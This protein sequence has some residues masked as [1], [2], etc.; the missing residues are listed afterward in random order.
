MTSPTLHGRLAD[1]VAD[2]FD[3]GLYLANEEEQRDREQLI[4][5]LTRAVSAQ[6]VKG[7]DAMVA[8]AA[9]AEHDRHQNL[10]GVKIRLDWDALHPEAK[11]LKEL[12]MRAAFDAASIPAVLEHHVELVGAVRALTRRN[13]TSQDRQAAQGYSRDLLDRIDAAARP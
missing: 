4:D 3:D 13:P 12:A 9:I 1:V 7:Y 8:A 2:Y 5:D 11:R 10:L 6:V